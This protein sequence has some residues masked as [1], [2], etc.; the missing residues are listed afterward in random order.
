[1]ATGVVLQRR[2]AEASITAA[3]FMVMASLAHAYQHPGEA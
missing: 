1:M 3:V 2:W